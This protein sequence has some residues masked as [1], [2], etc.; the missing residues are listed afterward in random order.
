VIAVEERGSETVAIV[1]SASA[2]LIAIMGV[3]FVALA[4]NRV[5]LDC[6]VADLD[7]Q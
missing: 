3:G 6:V 7:D 1:F 4:G 5:P 2:L